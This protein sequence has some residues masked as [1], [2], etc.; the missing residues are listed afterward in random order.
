MR[1]FPQLDK[2]LILIAGCDSD[3]WKASF[4]VEDMVKDYGMSDKVGIRVYKD[5]SRY[6]E[7]IKIKIE[8]EIN[9]MLQESY[10]RVFKL[11]SAHKAELDLLSNALLMKKTLFGDDIRE[12]IEESISTSKDVPKPKEERNGKPNVVFQ[13]TFS[14]TATK[15]TNDIKE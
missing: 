13:R 4:I 5:E 14:K 15:L 8:S 12:L 7:E 2:I 1:L 3:L 10:E 11:L 6:S 9:R